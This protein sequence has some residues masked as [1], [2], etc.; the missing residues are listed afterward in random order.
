M[1]YIERIIEIKRNEAKIEEPI[2]LYKGDKNI[3][4]QFLIENNPFKYKS[5]VELTYGQLVIKRPNTEPIFSDV[6]KL[7]NGKVL[8]TVTGEMI[9]ELVELGNYD[10]QI[11]LINAD[12]TSR[13]TLP[14]VFAGI[15]IKE[16]V[17]EEEGVNYSVVNYSKAATGEVLDVFDDEG[18]YIKTEWSNGD[19]I[20]D[21]KLNKIEGALYDI[22][23][24][25]DEVDLNGYITEDELNAK[26]YATETYVKNEIANAQLGGGDG[27]VD[28]SGYATKDYVDD[29][30]GDI[31]T[32]LG[33][34]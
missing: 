25:H 12:K 11:R 3:E 15:V 23:A 20:T 33:G 31:E 24:N 16:P 1:I 34:I 8:F 28:L 10:F 9:D 30:L 6:A 7:S 22:N 18:N 2:I 14:P 29:I 4:L 13:G 26:G 21:S 5:G 19:L 32:L 17:C 27:E